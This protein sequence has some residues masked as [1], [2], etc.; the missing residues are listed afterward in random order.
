MPVHRPQRVR[1]SAS[2]DGDV[3]VPLG[4]DGSESASVVGDAFGVVDDDQNASDIAV[5]CGNDRLLVG[6]D[7]SVCH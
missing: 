3:G 6:S 7:D 5:R 2:D 4:D 1:A